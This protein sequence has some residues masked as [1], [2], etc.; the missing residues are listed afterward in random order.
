M[1]LLVGHHLQTMLDAAQ[2]KISLGQLVARRGVDPAVGSEHGKRIDGLTATQLWMP[3][4]GDE[5]L[6]L[7]EKLDLPDAATAKFDIVAFDRDFT[8]AAISMDLL[9]HRMH[10]GNGGVVEI[11]APDERRQVADESL[12]CR[13]VAGDSACLDQRGAFPVLAPALVIIE[14]S[15]G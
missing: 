7:R 10:I 11:F 15:I 13:E 12:A 3:P 1:G 9:L 8:M 14:R 2:E 6:G 4:A 5:L